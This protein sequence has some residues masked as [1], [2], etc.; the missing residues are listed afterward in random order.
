MRHV[1]VVSSGALRIIVRSAWTRAKRW[2][3]GVRH[4]RSLLQSLRRGARYG[5]VGRS[6]RRARA[7]HGRPPP[8]SPESLYGV[9]G[10]RTR[11]TH[12]RRALL[13][14]CR[15]RAVRRTRARQSDPLRQYG[16]TDEVFLGYHFSAVATR[17]ARGQAGGGLFVHR[18][19]SRWTRD[20]SRLDDAPLAPPWNAD[21]RIAVHRSELTFDNERRHALWCKSRRGCGVRPADR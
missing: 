13:R 6:R 9:R 21:R 8:Y 16:G 7:R 18:K 17:R 1:A 14:A 11:C 20:N 3:F 15:P 2:S 19:P 10:G 4:P 12:G 5:T